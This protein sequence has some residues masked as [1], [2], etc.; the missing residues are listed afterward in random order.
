MRLLSLVVVATLAA[1][2]HPEPQVRP[3][4]DPNQ[5]EPEDMQPV[6]DGAWEVEWGEGS[7]SPW[8]ACGGFDLDTAAG[9]TSLTWDGNCGVLEGEFRENC[10]CY[11]HWLE[12]E[13]LWC[14]CPG[15]ESI[16]AD[17][18]TDGDVV[19]SFRARLR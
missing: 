9:V 14:V 1:C 17:I 11:P 16:T 3:D 13:R 2:D 6:T 12:G 7:E 19:A 18:R 15:V 10:R 5:P 8:T 4:A